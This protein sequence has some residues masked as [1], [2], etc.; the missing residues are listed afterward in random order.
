MNVHDD[1]TV[2]CGDDD[3]D[4]IMIILMV[5]RG[6]EKQDTEGCDNDN[7]DAHDHDLNSKTVQS[8]LQ[9]TVKE[10]L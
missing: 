4:E 10:M 1:G 2:D 5:S 7:D 8:S 9:Q 3:I 6:D